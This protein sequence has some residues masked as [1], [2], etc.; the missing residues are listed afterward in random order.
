MTKSSPVLRRVL[1]T[2]FNS[3]SRHTGLSTCPYTLATSNGR[4]LA[5]VHLQVLDSTVSGMRWRPG[6]ARPTGKARNRCLFVACCLVHTRSF[7]GRAA[8]ACKRRISS[9]RRATAD[10]SRP[11]LHGA[12]FTALFSF[13]ILPHLPHSL[14]ASRTH[15]SQGS[16]GGWGKTRVSGCDPP[17]RL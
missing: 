4:F 15:I 7:C 14:R 13:A 5:P 8:M 1:A 12:F 17:R 9:V 2:V 6:L 3:S 10:L 16:C 11:A